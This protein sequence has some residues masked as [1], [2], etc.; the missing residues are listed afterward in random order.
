MLPRSAEGA[1]R[2]DRLGRLR[3]I[4]PVFGAVAPAAGEYQANTVYDAQFSFI[5]KTKSHQPGLFMTV[6]PDDTK[7]PA[8]P[9]VD[10]RSAEDGIHVTLSDASGPADALFVTHPAGVLSHGQP[11]T[12]RFWIKV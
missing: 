2:V 10:L 3:S 1:L 4:A 7:A 11:H 8:C 5:S 6:S 9:G 12:I